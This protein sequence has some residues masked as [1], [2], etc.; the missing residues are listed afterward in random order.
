VYVCMMPS[1]KPLPSPHPRTTGMDPSKIMATVGLNVGRFEA[2]NTRL[3][4][5]DLGGAAS[6]RSIWEKYYAETHAIMYVVDAADGE[7]FDEAKVGAG[8]GGVVSVLDVSYAELCCDACWT[9]L[10]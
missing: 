5:W 1:P 7:R 2:F 4:F 8:S 9:G 10:C 6:L 3:V